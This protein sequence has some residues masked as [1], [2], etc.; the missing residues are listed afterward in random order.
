MSD[1]GLA[2]LL[3]L[4]S[5]TAC[6]LAYPRVLGFAIQHRIVDNPNARKLQRVPVPVMGGTAVF[7]GVLI[8]TVVGY[9]CLRDSRLLWALLLLFIMYLIGVWDDIKDVSAYFRFLVE[10][11][12][13]WA[14]I[15]VLHV[16]INDF[17]GLWGIHEVPDS[18]SI[19][20]SF[21]AGVGIINAVNL[22]DGVDGYCSYYGSWACIAFAIIF[23]RAGDM[24]M[25]SLALI[26]L[27]ALVPFFFHN[28]F[29]KTS[30][31]FLG[32]G[33]SLLLGMVLTLF[34]FNTLSSNSP[35]AQFAEEGLS[36]VALTLAI[37]AVPVFDTL[38]VMSYRVLRGHSPFR[39]DKSH[40]HHIFIEMEFSHLATSFIIVTA[41]IFIG[42]MVVVAWQLGA[43]IDLQ[44]Y[45]VIIVAFAFTAC[46]Y[47][48]MRYQRRNRTAFFRRMCSY[49]RQTHLSLTP[50]WQFLA[51]VVDSEF[52]AGKA[53]IERNSG[54]SKPVS[55]PDPRILE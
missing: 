29:G 4:A 49:G 12:L 9:I 38:K 44:V 40:L 42:I 24:A 18:I 41:N 11:L 34:T 5:F 27:G 13:V 2:L 23:F 43:S 30:K 55:R 47:F 19:P 50:F 33:G 6:M 17:H 46:F 32:D 16:E 8:A 52:L 26:T 48:Y 35:C 20:L 10:V 39:A 22:I 53:S 14:A 3:M 1:P 21:I 25:F 7:V 37:L 54:V 36:L 45:L 51:K 31:M 28:V 15:A